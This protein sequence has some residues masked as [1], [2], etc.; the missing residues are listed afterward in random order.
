MRAMGTGWRFT[1]QKSQ[2]VEKFLQNSDFSP[3]IGAEKTLIAVANVL[4][5]KEVSYVKLS[6]DVLC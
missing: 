5:T 1:V 4:L 6:G 3:K 2:C